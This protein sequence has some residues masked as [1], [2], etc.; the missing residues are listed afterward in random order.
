MSER[1][2]F[3]CLKVGV[4]ILALGTSSAFAQTLCLQSESVVF[5]FQESKSKKLAA[6][7]KGKDSAYLV[8][9]FGTTEKVELQFPNLLNENSWRKFEYSGRRRGGGK[10]NAGFG[11]YTLS[12]KNGPAEYYVF[13]EWNDEDSSYSIGISV[14]ANGKSKTLFGNKKTQLGS[15]VLLESEGENLRNAADD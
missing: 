14:Q 15:L 13:Q 2:M 10:Q 9:R 4:L 11:D 12:F 5:S 8:Y 7:C 6:I 3:K 1:R